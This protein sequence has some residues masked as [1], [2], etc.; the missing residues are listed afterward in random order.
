MLT[1]I[2]FG[3]KTAFLR[4]ALLNVPEICLNWMFYI[5]SSWETYWK[6]FK[7]FTFWLFISNDR[8]IVILNV[9]SVV[10]FAFYFLLQFKEIFYSA[11]NCSN[12]QGG[13]NL[14]DFMSLNFPLIVLISNKAR[15]RASGGYCCCNDFLTEYISKFPR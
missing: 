6:P 11:S 2:I 1:Q 9:H 3:R 4:D 7:S 10:W 8:N 13:R 14:L 15:C 12:L 5:S